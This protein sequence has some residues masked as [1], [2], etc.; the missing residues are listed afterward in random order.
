MSDS[1]LSD[2]PIAVAAFCPVCLPENPHED[3][4][5]KKTEGGPCSCR[6]QMETFCSNHQ[7]NRAGV[8]DGNVV[9]SDFLSGTAEAGGEENKAACDFFHRGKYGQ[10]G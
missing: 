10:A 8:E 5:Y 7:P 2:S 4:C 1:H 9:V 3:V 6:F